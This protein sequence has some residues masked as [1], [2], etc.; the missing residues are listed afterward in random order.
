MT[1]WLHRRI[2]NYNTVQA[3]IAGRKAAKAGNLAGVQTAVD[4]IVRGI[5]SAHIQVVLKNAVELDDAV[6]NSK[7]RAVPQVGPAPGC[8][9]CCPS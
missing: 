8:D 6:K 5:L 9:A 7:D 1:S 4:E 2:I 3:F